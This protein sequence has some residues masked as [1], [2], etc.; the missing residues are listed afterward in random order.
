MSSSCYG[1]YTLLF[2]AL[3]SDYTLTKKKQNK[4]TPNENE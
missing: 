1:A 4:Y 2:L 3:S